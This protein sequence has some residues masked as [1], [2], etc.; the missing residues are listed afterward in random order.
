MTYSWGA[1]FTPGVQY[2][3]ITGSYDPVRLGTPDGNPD[4][5][6]WIAEMEFSPSSKPDSPLNRFNVRLA[7]QFI[8]YS[9]FDGSRH[10]ASGNDT[11]LLHITAGADPGT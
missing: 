2:F 8:A 10:D 11:V 6:G 7:L 5:K 3:E 9:E 1:A 4:S